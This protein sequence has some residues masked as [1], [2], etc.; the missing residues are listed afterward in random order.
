MGATSAASALP[1]GAFPDTP[2][3]FAPGAGAAAVYRRREPTA[4]ALYPIVH[5]H[6]ELFLAHAE[7]RGDAVPRWVEDDFRA[8]L[9]C[10][11]LAHG[12]AR[13]R[14][15]ACGAGRLV[16]FSCKG[17]GLCPSC[18]TRRGRR[19]R[20]RGRWRS[21]VQ[22]PASIRQRRSVAG[23]TRMAGSARPRCS[24]SRVGPKSS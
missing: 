17:R 22:I 2:G 20:C 19:R 13:L 14:C 1:S 4:T 18:N 23:C 3:P 11:I 5:H 10:G 21:T 6:L 8:Y 15:G 24:P 7:A 9:A 16:A 12:F